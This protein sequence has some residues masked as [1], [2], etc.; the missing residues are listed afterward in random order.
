[1]I[2]LSSLKIR[3]GCFVLVS[4][5]Y[6]LALFLHLASCHFLAVVQLRS[7]H[8]PRKESRVSLV[9]SAD[10]IGAILTSRKAVAI[11]TKV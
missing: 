6:P 1:M 8:T 9:S 3:P 4:R 2:L 10:L 5:I 11:V 7:T